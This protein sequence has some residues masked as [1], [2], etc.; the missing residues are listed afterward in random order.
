[1]PKY[2]GYEIGKDITETQTKQLFKYIHNRFENLELIGLTQQQL[3][4][5][6][7]TNKKKWF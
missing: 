5:I 3:N 1:M 6:A 7:K 2:C 4:K